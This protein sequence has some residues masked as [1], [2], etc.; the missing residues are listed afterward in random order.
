MLLDIHNKITDLKY[1]FTLTF[2]NRYEI[3]KNA[4]DK[5]LQASYSVSD[6]NMKYLVN[7][8]D[9]ED[10]IAFCERT[11]G[12]ERLLN[13]ALA[14]RNLPSYNHAN[15]FVWLKR[16]KRLERKYSRLH[17]SCNRKIDKM[18]NQL[19]DLIKPIQFMPASK[20][21]KLVLDMY[22][23]L[24]HLLSIEKE[25]EA[26][27][28]T[29]GFDKMDWLFTIMPGFKMAKHDVLQLLS[30]DRGQ[31]NISDELCDLPDVLDESGF[32]M[33]IFAGK[34]EC[35]DDDIFFNLYLKRFMKAI[36]ENKELREKTWDAFTETFGPIPTY[37]ASIHSEGQLVRA[38]PN[39]PKL[40]VIE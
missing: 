2:A 20:L 29:Y 1:N 4:E 17:R 38:E 24:L 15:V 13:L 3:Y 10:F 5:L 31:L 6:A 14:A 36:D 28:K 19:E 16:L 9:E 23:D 34:V 18:L 11:K 26:P 40:Q 12:N 30:L 25:T 32:E 39:N 37:T 27:A 7:R 35:S 33:L 8:I 21:K 22:G